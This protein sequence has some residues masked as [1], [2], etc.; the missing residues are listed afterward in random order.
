MTS[1]KI[2]LKEGFPA[3]LLL[4]QIQLEEFGNCNAADISRLIR[5]KWNHIKALEELIQITNYK[6]ECKITSGVDQLTI[7]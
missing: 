6:H 2:L 4:T 3:N 1:I 7:F 5:D